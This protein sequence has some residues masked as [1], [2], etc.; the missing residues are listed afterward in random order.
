M[1]YALIY[2]S[3][4]VQPL[5]E[6]DVIEIATKAASKNK[7]IGVTGFLTS[8]NDLFVQFLEGSKESVTKLMNAIDADPRHQVEEMI[9]LKD[10]SFRQF[11]NWNMRYLSE[12]N[13]N[14]VTMDD[15]LIDTIRDIG[16][17]NYDQQL[18]NAQVF[19]VINRISRIIYLPRYNPTTEKE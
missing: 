18:I 4:M 10:Q 1:I 7:K 11:E 2:L 5:D 15:T 8:R 13:L 14:R 9:L 16:N 6:D 17:N 19:G 3:K 12:A